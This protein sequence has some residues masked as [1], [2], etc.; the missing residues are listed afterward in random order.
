M[1][2]IGSGAR[3]IALVGP[4]GAGKTSVAEALLYA[5]GAIPRL[6]SV[7]AGTTQGD[8]SPEARSRNS[9]TELNLTRF[10]WA[11]DDYVLL[12]CPGSIGFASDGD[13]ALDIADLALVVITPEAERAALAEPVLRELEERGVPHIVF[14]NK[15]DKARGGI[16]A[17]LEALQPLSVV[18]VVDR[19]I[20]ISE[21]EQAIGFVDL[22]LDRAFK[23]RSGQPSEQVPIPDELREEEHA[24]RF[25]M[26]EQLADHDDHLLE[27]LLNDEEPDLA[28]VCGDLKRETAEG[29][30]VPVMLG[31][32]TGGGGMRR[33][34]KALRH[35]T[36][37]PAATAKRLGI[38]G[39]AIEVFKV[40]NDTS[41][42]RLALGRV[43][44][45]ALLEGSDL[46]ARDGETHRAGALFG[47]QGGSTVRLKQAGPGDIV[48]IAKADDVH[49]GDRLGI[50][51]A[52]PSARVAPAPRTAN[53]ALSISVRDHKDEVRLSTALNKLTEE[54]RGLSWETTE[55]THET[56]LRGINDEHLSLALE[57]LK[58]R[59]GLE[60]NVGPPSVAIKESIRKSVTQRGRHK[61][62][63][64]GHGQYGDV[65]I[66]VRP[67]PRGAGFEFVD[68]ITGGV[69]PRQYIP[70][71]EAGIKDAM[72]KGP[73][74]CQVVDVAVTLTDGSYHSVDS[75]EL[76]FRTAGRI[77]MSEALAAA[78]PYLLEPIAHVTIQCPGSATSRITSALPSRRARVLGMAPRDGWSRWD[79]VEAQVPEAEMTGF[80]TDV[81]SLSQGMA[82]FEAKFDHLAEVTG[83]A[84][85]TIVQRAPEP[86]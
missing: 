33:L 85:E 38:D 9:S 43:F 65:V 64:G 72:L 31:S 17:L 10:A 46:T 4:A 16:D 59:Y 25:H 21:G 73:L 70:A 52:K 2:A 37:S 77:A 48:G 75:S 41:V 8:A 30:V 56:L 11:G 7:D 82:T 80:Q 36:P 67:L 28:T 55:G 60:V 39:P 32:A 23:F 79:T 26:L 66:E 58:R 57:R 14:I 54:D 24:A 51:G 34:L 18:P 71:V 74:G 22:A 53:S 63:S 61:K 27:V 5:A 35:D 76:A 19:Q 68:K 45:K 78:S 12:D 44:G 84:A 62:Q 29:L 86:A 13:C 42:G 50:D 49:A 1:D 69:I 83:K 6:G 20:P 47:V 81:R 15:I 40:A 3:A